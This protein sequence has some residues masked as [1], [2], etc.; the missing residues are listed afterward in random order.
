LVQGPRA[1]LQT[2]EQLERQLC[3]SLK[4]DPEPTTLDQT[5]RMQLFLAA[6]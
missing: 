5:D 2:E 4:A 6:G 1:T 3:A